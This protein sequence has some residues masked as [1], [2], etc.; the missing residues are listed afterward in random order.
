MKEERIIFKGI[1]AIIRLDFAKLPVVIGR[2]KRKLM[3]FE[4]KLRKMREAFI[5][6]QEQNPTLKKSSG[7]LIFLSYKQAEGMQNIGVKIGKGV[8]IYSMLKAFAMEDPSQCTLMRTAA[9]TSDTI[10][11]FVDAFFDENEKGNPK[12]EAGAQ[13]DPQPEAQP[14]PATQDQ[15]PADAATETE[16]KTE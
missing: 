2:D 5:R 8:H 11:E 4:R 6:L 15:Q 10:P 14:A 16:A 12:P 13:S 1:D 9:V 7:L 3:R